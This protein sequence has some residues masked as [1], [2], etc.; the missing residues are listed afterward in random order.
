MPSLFLDPSGGMAG[1]MLL[2]ALCGLGFDPAP[3][4]LGLAQQDILATVRAVDK[5]VGGLAGTGM[6]LEFPE[7]QPLRHLPEV[8]DVASG[9]GMPQPV[10]ERCRAAFVRLA[11]TE[12]HVHG[13]G[14][15]TIHFHEVGA[16]DTVVDVCGAFWGLHELHIDRVI[17]APVPWFS[18]RVECAHGTLPLPAP[19]TLRLLRGKP[20]YPTDV[21]EEII[22]PTGALILD[23]A[24]DEFATGPH[25]VVQASATGYGTRVIA[26]HPNGLRA[27][28]MESE[29]E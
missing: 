27:V 2:A 22:T 8:L 15:D 19:A 21:R 10:L 9:L 25:G 6:E 4:R 28:L 23:M 7:D 12:A 14:V 26:N 5:S 11:E 13:V 1:D 16:L 18:G 20:V 24:V 29:T 3:L 17:C